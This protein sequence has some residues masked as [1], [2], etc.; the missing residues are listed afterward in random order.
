MTTLKCQEPPITDGWHEW[1][2]PLKPS[3][4]SG[5]F[6]SML[7]NIPP[8]KTGWWTLSTGYK[9]SGI[10]LTYQK[11]GMLPHKSVMIHSELYKHSS[12]LDP[13]YL[14]IFNKGPY[15]L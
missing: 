1:L 3:H 2:M 13:V 4:S 11:E 10:F 14:S 12:I 7:R 15:S 9:T 8:S 6:L 5:W